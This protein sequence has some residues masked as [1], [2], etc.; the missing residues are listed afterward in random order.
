MKNF[1]ELVNYQN[2]LKEINS[3]R[4]ELLNEKDKLRQ[5]VR[6]IEE[7]IAP[8]KE[9]INNFERQANDRYTEIDNLNK[10]KWEI[11]DQMSVAIYKKYFQLTEE[12]VYK[13]EDTIAFRFGDEDGVAIYENSELTIYYVGWANQLRRDVY[14]KI[15]YEDRLDEMKDEAYNDNNFLR[16]MRIEDIEDNY[17]NDSLYDFLNGVILETIDLDDLKD[18][19]LEESDILNMLNGMEDNDWYEVFNDEDEYFELNST[20]WLCCLSD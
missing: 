20:R 3:K 14:D 9:M 2:Q 16:K 6:E 15:S 10:K 8:D 19:P 18:D 17:C 12:W 1:E 5:K 11:E 13:D 7:K 4:M